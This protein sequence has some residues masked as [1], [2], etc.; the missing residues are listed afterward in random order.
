MK[1]LN[2]D[3]F[4][5]KKVT[6]KEIESFL[7]DWNVRFPYDRLWRNKYKIPFRSKEHLEANQIDIYIDI[8]EDLLVRKIQ[9]QHIEALKNKEDYEKTGVMLREDKMTQEE[10]DKIFKNLK[11]PTKENV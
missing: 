8:V 1:L 5:N 4:P 11:F 10:E 6:R 2:S 9:Q 3:N 7:K